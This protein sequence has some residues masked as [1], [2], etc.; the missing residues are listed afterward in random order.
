MEWYK[1][2][3]IILLSSS[4]LL[5]CANTDKS[6]SNEKV[7]VVKSHSTESF[8]GVTDEYKVYAIGEIEEFVKATDEFTTAVI[9]GENEKAKSLYALARMHYERAEPIAEVFGDLDP[10]I[11]AREGD[12]PEQEWGDTTG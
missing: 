8:K 5:G 6:S 2:S 10:K 12:V 7:K 3:G 4:L 9:N 1:V 11:D